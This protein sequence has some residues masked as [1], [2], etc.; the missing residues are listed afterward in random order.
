MHDR[1]VWEYIIELDNGGKTGTYATK[2]QSREN[3]VKTL[4]QYF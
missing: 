1:I 2:Y 4:D 3:D